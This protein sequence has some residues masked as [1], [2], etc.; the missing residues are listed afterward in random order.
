MLNSKAFENFVMARCEEI[1]EANQTCAD[2][3]EKILAIENQ[4]KESLS[5]DQKCQ[6]DKITDH[7]EELISLLSSVMYKT[8]F[9]D[10][11]KK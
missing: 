4:L 11:Q 9:S 5:P 8:G 2:L 1:L 10:Q 7:V 6:Y 3:K